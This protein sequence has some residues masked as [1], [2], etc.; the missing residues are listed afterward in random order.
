MK[1]IELRTEYM[2]LG[3]LLK[4]EDYVSSGGEAKAFLAEHENEIWV[5]GELENRRGKKLYN[6]TIVKIIDSEYEF[7]W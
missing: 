5:N 2:T 4:L 6:G 7:V 1:K 3:Q